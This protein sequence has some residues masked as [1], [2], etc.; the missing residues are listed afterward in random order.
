MAAITN[1]PFFNFQPWVL[2]ISLV[3]QKRKFFSSIVSHSIEVL[4]F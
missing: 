3:E 1:S 2:V 4:K